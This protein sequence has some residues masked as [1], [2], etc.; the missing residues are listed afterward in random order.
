MYDY[1]HVHMT[2][3]VSLADDAYE[4]LAA[5]KNPDESFSDLA[6]R[7]AHELAKSRLFDPTFKVSWTDAEARKLIADIYRARDASLE[8]RTK[9]S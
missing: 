3:T 4:A 2:K 5:V 9:W 8:P 1:M 7:A 6:R